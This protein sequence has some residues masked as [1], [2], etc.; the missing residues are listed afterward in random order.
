[1]VDGRDNRR[2]NAKVY[3][4][5]K[6]AHQHRKD[7][8]IRDDKLGADRPAMERFGWYGVGLRLRSIIYNSRFL[9][10]LLCHLSAVPSIT[11]VSSG[12]RSV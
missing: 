9:A 4:E 11:G 8:N 3:C 5:A 6:R 12:R 2:S 7:N 1:M 10:I